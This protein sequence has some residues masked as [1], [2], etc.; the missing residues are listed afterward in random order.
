MRMR[1][2]ALIPTFLFGLA[3]TCRAITAA[4]TAAIVR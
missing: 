3:E 2:V 4:P 1:G